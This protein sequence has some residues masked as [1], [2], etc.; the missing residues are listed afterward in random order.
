MSSVLDTNFDT[1]AK[2]VI[3]LSL[4]RGVCD[5]TEVAH[6]VAQPAYTRNAKER[7]E[8]QPLI[9]LAGCTHMK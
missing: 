5:F 3:V 9:T 8:A 1:C 2:P 6:S 4:L 7:R